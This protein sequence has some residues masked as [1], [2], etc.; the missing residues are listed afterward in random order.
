MKHTVVLTAAMPDIAT[1]ILSRECDVL[2][3]ISDDPRTEEDLIDILSDADGA[4]TILTDPVTRRVLSSNPNLRIVANCAVGTDNIDLAAAGELGI[5]VSNTP[6]VLTDAT[7]DLTF[8]LILAAT[9]RILEGD[10]MIR[11]E[12]FSGWQPLMLLGSELRES[13]IGIVGMG[14]IGF[15]VAQRARA[16]GMSVGYHSRNAHPETE[17]A[18]GSIRLALDA[19]LETSDIVSLHAPLTTDTAGMID[20]RALALMKPS[21]FLINT[22]RGALV[23]EEALAAALE[24]GRLRGAGLD[25]YQHEPRVHARLLPL[26]NVVLLPHLGSATERTRDAMARIAATNVLSWLG[27]GRAPNLVAPK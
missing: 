20:S 11:N 23:D 13:R 14:R 15:A 1:A 7:A 6:G 24:T 12:E 3:H 17:Q 19:L 27:T 10:A 8:A 16:F 22:A 25:V 18:H 5:A 26:S 4:I 9:R 2:T 21:A